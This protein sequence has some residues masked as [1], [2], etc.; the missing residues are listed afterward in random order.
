MKKNLVILLVFL[1][2][3]S[4]YSKQ[5]N[6][7]AETK[8]M[9]AFY[10]LSS[11][12]MFGAEQNVIDKLLNQYNSLKFIKTENEF[13]LS[14]AF[15]VSIFTKKRTLAIFWVDE[16]GVFSISGE[17]YV[18]SSGSLDYDYLKKIYEVSKN[19]DDKSSDISQTG[20]SSIE[21]G[22]ISNYDIISDSK[23][24]YSD[25]EQ[26]DFYQQIVKTGNLTMILSFDFSTKRFTIPEKYKNEFLTTI[27][28]NNWV[29]VDGVN[30]PN[31]EWYTITFLDRDGIKHVFEFLK[32]DKNMVIKTE[33]TTDESRKYKY[34]LADPK[35]FEKIAELYQKCIPIFETSEKSILGIYKFAL[36]VASKQDNLKKWLTA[37]NGVKKFD[38]IA[39]PDIFSELGVSEKAQMIKYVEEKTGSKIL[40]KTHEECA[41]EGIADYSRMNS[42][43]FIDA[44]YSEFSM[45]GYKKDQKTYIFTIGFLTGALASI[46][47]SFKAEL[48]NNMW[49]VENKIE[50]MES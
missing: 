44:K 24:D 22:M 50:I 27:N 39:N 33:I 13:N 45:R 28:V 48:K 31:D 9:Y 15:N 35:I 32:N 38:L 42:F 37:G 26:L 17:H 7:V 4:A 25:I 11:Y 46:G 16:N 5:A 2:I 34:Y 18:I 40:L 29:S 1:L 30:I 36:D 23:I 49:Q 43:G 21:S 6:F 8:D 20:S 47:C 41:S 12:V 10:G 19:E 3:A 14:K